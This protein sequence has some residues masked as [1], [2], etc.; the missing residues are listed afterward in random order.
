MKKI[1]VLFAVLA[2]AG[3]VTPGG[4]QKI[5]I[6]GE[7]VVFTIHTPGGPVGVQMPKGFL[8]PEYEGDNYITQRELDERMDAFRRENTF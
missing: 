1:I 5:D 4:G 6:P 8:N 3:C 7:D 2:M